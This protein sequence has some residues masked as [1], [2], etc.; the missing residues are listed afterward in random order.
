MSQ[1]FQSNISDTD[2]Y[3]Y[4]VEATVPAGASITK[5]FNIE[6]D[7]LFTWMQT[8]SFI[9]DF[10]EGTTVEPAVTVEIND[11]GSGRLLQQ[12]PVY[13]KSMSGTGIL[14]YILPR[15]RDFKP[16]SSVRVKFD[17]LGASEKTIQLNLQGI[18]SW[19]FGSGGMR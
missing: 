12:S 9:L 16:N 13:I 6:T 7:S 10:I 5:T 3:T 14:P 19:Q 18:K 15:T 1:Q 8:T 11:T 17:N 2:I 4:S